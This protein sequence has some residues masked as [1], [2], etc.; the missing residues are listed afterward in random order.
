[1]IKRKIN[2]SRV[3]RGDH[4]NISGLS[5]ALIFAG[6]ISGCLKHI[7]LS[8][9]KHGRCGG[10]LGNQIPVDGI[11]MGI[12]RIPVI[13]ILCPGHL[14][15]FHQTGHAERSVVNT[16]CPVLTPL[17]SGSLRDILS[18]GIQRCGNQL[19]LKGGIRLFQGH[20][21]SIIVKR[22]CFHIVHRSGTAVIF[23]RTYD[24]ENERSIIITILRI[25]QTFPA[26]LIV[27]GGYRFSVR[28]F[29]IL[30]Q[31]ESIYCS[32]LRNIN[33]LRAVQDEMLSLLISYI[34]VKSGIAGGHH[35]APSHIL[36]I[37]VVT[38][39]CC[40]D[41]QYLSISL[42]A[43]GAAV[44]CG[45]SI[46]CGT[47]ALTGGRAAVASAAAGEYGNSHHSCKK[48]CQNLFFHI[49]PPFVM[50]R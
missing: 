40:T 6:V 5:L 49:V 29:G 20:L 37:V 38:E 11:Q 2:R 10:V 44:L 15:I 50:L 31:M 32:V 9:V 43:S 34:T 42:C 19:C 46:I 24:I 45:C 18:G 26:I 17:I 22:H 13:L 28:P 23:F 48:K 21:K 14:V 12:L 27:M 41:I 16:Q 47:A 33:A 39:A 25:Q 30:S 8:V 35:P 1:M 4:L 7:Q 3:I 36:N